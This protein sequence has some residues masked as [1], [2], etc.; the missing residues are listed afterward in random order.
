MHLK[1]SVFRRKNGTFTVLSAPEYDPKKGRPARRSLGT[2]A[3]EE[4]ARQRQVEYTNSFTVCNQAPV[5]TRPSGVRLRI[6]LGVR[7]VPHL[8]PH[9]PVPIRMCRR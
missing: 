6:P 1:G 5:A 4:L 7:E 8:R 3:T 2:F 9:H